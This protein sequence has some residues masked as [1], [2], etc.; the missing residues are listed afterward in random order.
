MRKRK[1]REVSSSSGAN[2]RNCQGG[3]EL[4]YVCTCIILRINILH[5]RARGRATTS[6]FFSVKVRGS[7]LA[8][9][10]AFSSVLILY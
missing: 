6:T 3:G 4:N 2:S 10:D 8:P 1:R 5:C 9:D 7:I